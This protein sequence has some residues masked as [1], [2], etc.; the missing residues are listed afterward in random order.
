MPSYDQTKFTSIETLIHYSKFD[1]KI[2]TKFEFFFPH[3]RSQTSPVCLFSHMRWDISHM[4]EQTDRRWLCG[5]RN[6]TAIPCGSFLFLHV[7]DAIINE[8]RKSSSRR[9]IP[10]RTRGEALVP[11]GQKG[12]RPHVLRG[13]GARARARARA[14]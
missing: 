6:S 4:G 8:N 13:P 7:F 14:K 9:K 12:R 2:W 5:K 1:D 11:L 10:A 3:T